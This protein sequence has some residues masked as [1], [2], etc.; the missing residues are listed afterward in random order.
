MLT[1]AQ[2]AHAA[3]CAQPGITAAPAPTAEDEYVFAGQYTDPGGRTRYGR[4]EAHLTWS[5]VEDGRRIAWAMALAL[6]PEGA[7]AVHDRSTVET[8]AGDPQAWIDLVRHIAWRLALLRGDTGDGYGAT[9]WLARR[10][11]TWDDA[12]TVWSS[13]EQG[14]AHLADQ[15]RKQWQNVRYREGMPADPPADAQEV[16]DLYYGPSEEWMD[17]GYTYPYPERIDE[18]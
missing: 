8:S 3:L 12:T 14:L 4:L 10:W 16:L 9:V 15:V 18:A 13:P 1:L 2:T 5:P 6:E 7:E 17:E 11:D